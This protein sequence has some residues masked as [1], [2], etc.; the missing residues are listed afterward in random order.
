[1]NYA[2]YNYYKISYMG[3]LEKSDFER[4]IV[5]ASK[6]IDYNVNQELTDELIESLS[7]SA[8]D[9]LKYTACAL[10]DLTEK[11]NNSDNRKITAYSIDGVNKTYA[12]IT[13]E[14]YKKKE[15]EALKFLPDELTCYL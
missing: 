8:Q 3:S 10:T 13:D 2:D 5:K 15:N 14:D 6:I 4:N 12:T 1:M 7:D 9:K 11:K